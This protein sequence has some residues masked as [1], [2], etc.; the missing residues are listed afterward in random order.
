MRRLRAALALLAV[1]CAPTPAVE[2]PRP[3]EKPAL[4]NPCATGEEV[5]GVEGGVEGGVAG[6]LVADV[7]PG[8]GGLAPARGEPPL[9]GA[10]L[11]EIRLVHTTLGQGARSEG[12]AIYTAPN[13]LGRLRLEARSPV[14]G[15]G[16]KGQLDRKDRKKTTFRVSCRKE[17]PKHTVPWTFALVD[18]QGN[19]SNEIAVTMECTGQPIPGAAPRLDDVELASADLPLNGRTKATAAVTGTH[20]PYQ[21]I[22]SVT[23]RGNGWKGTSQSVWTDRTFSVACDSGDMPHVIDL[24][25]R[26]KDSFGR[27]SN[28]VEKRL[29]CGDCRPTR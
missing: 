6:G 9:A 28:V 8:V 20:P 19:R 10:R 24:R 18:A 26:V 15:Y 29:I 5:Q 22:A 1:A 23:T 7:F 17:R 13:A 4:T 16:W 14:E 12:T 11:E 21:V 3:A 2:A 27:E 25:F